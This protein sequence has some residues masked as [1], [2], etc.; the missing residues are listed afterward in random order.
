MSIL[1]LGISDPVLFATNTR[2]I[3]GH[4]D[5]AASTVFFNSIR[6]PPLIAW[7]AVMMVSASAKTKDRTCTSF[8]NTLRVQLLRI[9]TYVQGKT[10]A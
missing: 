8:I 9:K 10:E 1:P 3:P 7:S 2:F 6:F 4:L 5:T